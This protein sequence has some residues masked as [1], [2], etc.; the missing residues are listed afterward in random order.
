MIENSAKQFQNSTL[1]WFEFVRFIF[2]RILSNTETKL[3]KP[4]YFD[5][6]KILLKITISEKFRTQA[7]DSKDRAS[8]LKKGPKT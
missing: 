6:S 3:K 4:L 2:L 1:K 8:M 7:D 5:I